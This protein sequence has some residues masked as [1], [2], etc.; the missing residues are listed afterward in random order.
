MV[1]A[2]PLALWLRQ[3]RRPRARPPNPRAA[4][5]S[6]AF[7]HYPSSPGL[8]RSVR[9]VLPGVGAS[10]PPSF[11]GVRVASD[12]NRRRHDSAEATISRQAFQKR[13]LTSLSVNPI[14]L[15]HLVNRHAV[16]E[17]GSDAGELRRRYLTRRPRLG[18]D[19]RF[20]RIVTDWRRRR[21]DSQNASFARR[22]AVVWPR[23]F[24]ANGAVTGG[25]DVNSASAT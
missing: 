24:R 5:Q 20:D 11:P 8:G 10:T 15:R 6:A 22:L 13:R 21:D 1:Q 3:E 7:P 19:R 17:P 12:G 16:F 25:L 9:F 2:R 14:D 4:E 23:G 18:T